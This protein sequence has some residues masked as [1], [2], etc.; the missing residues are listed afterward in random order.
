MSNLTVGILKEAFKGKQFAVIDELVADRDDHEVIETLIDTSQLLAQK[1]WTKQ[2]FEDQ[3]MDRGIDFDEDLLCDVI[4]H[5]D[6]SDLSDITDEEWDIVETAIASS[7]A[8]RERRE[9]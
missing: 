2:D 5:P 8:K 6:I 9:K 7:L 1:I 4:N 3:L